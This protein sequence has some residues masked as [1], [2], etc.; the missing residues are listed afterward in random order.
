MKAFSNMRIS[1]SG[2]SAERL[3]M[4][5]ISSNIVNHRTTRGSNGKPYVR[6]V[7]LFEENLRSEIDRE[8]G[9]SSKKLMGIKSVGVEEDS[10]PL[11]RVYEPSHPDADDNGYVTMPNVNILNEVAD[12]ISA[13]RAYEANITAIN[14]EKGILLKSIEIGR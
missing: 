3:R 1:S 11:R 8:T 5:T 4:D 13:S 10:S 7:A 12:L 9:V 2:L 14:A 6:K